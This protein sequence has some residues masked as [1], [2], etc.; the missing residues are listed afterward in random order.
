[1]TDGKHTQEKA[2]AIRIPGTT[3]P[4]LPK[5]VYETVTVT[6]AAGG[7][8]GPSGWT[9]LLDGGGVRTPAKRALALPSP[10][11]AEAVAAEWSAQGANIDPRTMPVTRLVNT[12]IDGVVGREAEVRESIRAYAG[13]DLLCYR[14][15]EP[16]ALADRQAAGWQPLIDWAQAE[17]GIALRTTS[18]MMPIEQDAQALARVGEAI[19]RHDAF[20]LAA[21]HEITTLTGS[22]VLAL[23]CARRR[24]SPVEAWALAHI[25]EDFQ[26][27]QWGRDAEAEERRAARWTTMRAAGLVLGWPG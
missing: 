13:H 27:E 26:A 22:L 14:A 3:A 5:R 21:L 16:D 11:L 23:A 18:G 2:G 17:L 15:N 8:S 9:I 12:V 7:E 24:L 25:D 10:A 20:A 4:A 19:D 1:M 6:P